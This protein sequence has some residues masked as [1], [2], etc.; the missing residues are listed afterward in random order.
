MSGL[1]QSL[2]TPV[3]ARSPKRASPGTH[4][5]AMRVCAAG[6]LFELGGQRW[7]L[8]GLTYGPF[9]PNSSGKYF[10]ELA[11]LAT[12]FA[13]ARALGANCLRVYHKPTPALL[14]L[15]LEHDLRIFVD[16]PW[17]KHRCFFEDWS[18]LQDARR[19]VRATAR[20]L[21]GLPGLFALS[22][23]NEIPSDVVRFYGHRRVGRFV[24]EL[25]DVVKQ[26]APTCLATFANYPST[27]FL[28]PDTCDFHCFNVYLKDGHTLGSYLDRLQHLAGS[29]PLILGEF[30]A[31]SFRNGE[32]NQ[33]GA[34]AEH[35]SRVFHHGLA[36]SFVF[37]FTDDWFTGGHQIEDWAFGV[38]R[39]DRSEKP[40]AAALRDAW[41][42]APRVEPRSTPR[43]S[44]VVCTY[45]GAATLRECLNSLVRLNYPNYEVIVVDDG[46]SDATP[47]ITDE[48]PTVRTIRQQNRGLSVARNVG[49]AAATGDVVAYTDSDCVADPDWLDYLLDAMQRQQVEAIGGPNL[50]PPTDAWIAQCVAASPGGPSHVMLDDQLAEHI[51]GCNMAFRRDLLLKIGGFDPQFRQAG[52]DVDICWRWID[53][54]YRIGYAASAVVWHHRRN[55]VRAFM[56]QQR[57]YGRSEAML[58]FKHPE[59][60]NRL[61]C[62]RWRGVIYGEGAV[63]LPISEPAVFHGRYGSGLFQTIY[64]RNDYSIWAYFTLLEWHVLAVFALVMSLAFPPLAILPLAMWAATFA[65]TVRSTAS[66]PLCRSAPSWCRPL[67][68]GL[69]ILQPVIRAANRYGYRLQRKRLPQMPPGDSAPMKRI[70]GAV[71]DAYWISRR[72][73]GREELLKSLEAEARQYGWDGSFQEEWRCWDVILLGDRWHNLVLHTATEELGSPKRFTR[74]RCSLQMSTFAAAICATALAAVVLALVDGRWP[75]FNSSLCGLLAG[76]LLFRLFISR[77]RCFAAVSS[78]LGAAG[79]EAGLNPIDPMHNGNSRLRRRSSGASESVD[80]DAIETTVVARHAAA[81]DSAAPA[82]GT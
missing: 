77:R 58:L 19:R 75:L 68:F 1:F 11:R 51:P 53:E 22:V 52:D 32:A 18:A 28:R 8:K 57:G 70:S 24:E 81:M 4:T 71:R 44:I 54:G 55:T 56:N 7:L 43:V 64:H 73:R 10:P 62:S 20:E 63:G 76:G 60:F 12:D 45:N 67:V 17:Q 42:R 50:P 23:A 72:G 2:I 82:S 65:A 3:P 25:I 13:Q 80:V 6:K 48:F 31:D 61:G 35:V 16:V 74:V 78:L 66:S 21:G 69:H 5:A 9:A 15:A 30:G 36:G 79:R 47:Q 29:K 46:S 27:E 14:D 49:A 26:E 41:A 38:T 39:L 33:A 40:A 37:S 59:R 34:L